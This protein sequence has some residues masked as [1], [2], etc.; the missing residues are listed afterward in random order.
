[1]TSDSFWE[2]EGQVSLSL[3][4]IGWKL[5]GMTPHSG[6]YEWCKRDLVSYF[7]KRR[8]EVGRQGKGRWTWD[9]TKIY[10]MEF[11]IYI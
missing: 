3:A 6:I 8:C 4:P 1:L 11:L 5:Q 10:S 2:K 9:M 7:L